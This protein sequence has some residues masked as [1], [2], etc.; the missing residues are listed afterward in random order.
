[1]GEFKYF[2]IGD[3]VY[4][5]PH[6]AMLSELPLM[7]SEFGSA[8]SKRMREICTKHCVYAV[9]RYNAA[10][11][12]EQ[13]DFYSPAVALDDAKFY[14]RTEAMMKIHPGCII[15]AVHKL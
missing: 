7:L 15:Y 9:K 4:I 13:V 10:G 1:M 14:K 6:Y 12:I 5:Q 11:D 8:A 3:S 2:V